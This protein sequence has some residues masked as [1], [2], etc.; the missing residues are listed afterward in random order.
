MNTNIYLSLLKCKRGIR[1]GQLTKRQ[2]TK[3]RRALLAK[4]N[5]AIYDLSSSVA[6]LNIIKI[7]IIYYQNHSR[8]SLVL[9]DITVRSI[10]CSMRGLSFTSSSGDKLGQSSG[11]FRPC[12][13]VHVYIL[14]FQRHNY[15]KTRQLVDFQPDLCGLV[16]DIINSSRNAFSREIIYIGKPVI[17]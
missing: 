7:K 9:P 13:Q 8:A 6:E 10:R 14:K 4:L 12:R 15:M 3:Y 2:L 17:V 11:V 5:K 1:P 16:F